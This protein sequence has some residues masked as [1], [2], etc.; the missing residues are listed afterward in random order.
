M[1]DQQ[2]S[3]VTILQKPQKSGNGRN[4]KS[5]LTADSIYFRVKMPESIIKRDGRIVPFNMELIEKALLKCYA[6]LPTEPQT[7]ASEIAHRVV[8]V[9][10]AKYD[11]IGRASCR[12]RV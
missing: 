3:G 7:P 9:V 12:E 8:N 1:S 2:N 5:N 11:Q 10:A 6:S 4:G